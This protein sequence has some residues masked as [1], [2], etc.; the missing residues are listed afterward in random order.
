MTSLT[1]VSDKGVG[2]T[3][4]ALAQVLGVTFR[5][6]E[7]SYRGGDYLLAGE[8]DQG[9]HII[10]QRNI[11]LDVDEPAIAGESPSATVVCVEETTRP[12]QVQTALTDIDIRLVG[13][14]EPGPI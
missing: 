9:E 13:R 10:V 12:D 4:T 5:H 8:A 14:T 6:R 1:F 7:S 2:P 11:D 3:G